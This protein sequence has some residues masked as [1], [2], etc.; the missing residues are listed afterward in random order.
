MSSRV[1]DRQ[2][3]IRAS[4]CTGCKCCEI[5]CSFDLGAV[6]DPAISKIKITRYNETG[7]IICSLSP[8]CP[9]C[10]FEDKPPC[11]EACIFGTLKLEKGRG[12]T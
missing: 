9:E 2:L 11:V 4:R 3:K 8:S 10:F 7:E 5:A 12:P 6:C 1:Q